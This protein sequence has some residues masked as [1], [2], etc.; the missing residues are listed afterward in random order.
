MPPPEI[1]VGVQKSLMLLNSHILKMAA[2][3]KTSAEPYNRRAVDHRRS[4]RWALSN[5]NNSVLWIF[6][7]NCLWRCGKIYGFRKVQR[8]FQYASEEESLERTH[9]ENPRNRW[10]SSSADFGWSRAIVAKISIDCWCKR[11][12][13][14]SNCRGGPSTDALWSCQEQP[15]CTLRL[16]IWLLNSSDLNPLDYYV[17]SIVES[18]T[19]KSRHP[20]VMSLRTAIEVAFVGMDS[21]TL[22][23]ACEHFRSSFKLMGNILNNCALQEFPKCHVKGFF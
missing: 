1:V 18:V 6:E 22:Q 2:M 15:S 13:N 3:L 5:G 20:I 23:R 19:N 8:R 16:L 17:W 10:K 12:N 14:A 21:T 9:R 11:A 7:I 4:S